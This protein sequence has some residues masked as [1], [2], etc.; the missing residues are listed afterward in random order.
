VEAFQRVGETGVH[1]GAAQPAQAGGD[2]V[3]D[4]RLDES[5]LAGRGLG[6][7]AG[8]EP[9]V[10]ASSTAASSASAASVSASTS[11]PCPAHRS[12]PG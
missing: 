3:T 1:A 5:H 11:V 4:Q 10:E 6:Q 12:M 7:Q 8:D 9:G 2:R